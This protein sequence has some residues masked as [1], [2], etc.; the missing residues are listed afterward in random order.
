MQTVCSV[1]RLSV[2]PSVRIG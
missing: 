2:I 1:V